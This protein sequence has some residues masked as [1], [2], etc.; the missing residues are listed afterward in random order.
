MLSP[1]RCSTGT[2]PGRFP[3]RLCAD[4]GGRRAA[5]CVSV[6]TLSRRLGGRAQEE[7]CPTTPRKR[8][9]NGVLSQLSNDPL[10]E[11]EKMTENETAAEHLRHALMYEAELRR[12]LLAA[13]RELEAEEDDEKGEDDAAATRREEP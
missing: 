12:Q 10:Y 11:E 6:S 13:L 9:A 1:A 8:P 2:K 7:K 5:G 4:S 3:L